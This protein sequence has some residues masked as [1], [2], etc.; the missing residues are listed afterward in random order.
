MAVNINHLCPL[1]EYNAERERF[2]VQDRPSVATGQ[3]ALC[4][5]LLGQTLRVRIRVTVVGIANPLIEVVKMWDGLTSGRFG[6]HLGDDT[7]RWSG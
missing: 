2:E 6:T 7:D 5:L 4:T 1:R 3:D